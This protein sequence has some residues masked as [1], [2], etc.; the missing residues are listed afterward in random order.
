MDVN[1]RIEQFAKMAEADPENELGHFSLGKAL[2]EA[3][4]Y[5]EAV[6]SL[7]RVIELNREFS[8]AYQVLAFAQMSM[9]EP[10][11]ALVTL[12]TGIPIADT[13]GDRIPRDEMAAM[14]RELGETPPDFAAATAAAE[15]TGG[16]DLRCSRCGRPSKRMERPP[17]KGELGQRVQDNV[18]QTCWRE[19]VSMGT[20]V[21]NE[22]GLQLANPKSQEA[23]DEHM[24]EFLQI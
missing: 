15:P 2:V 12:R 8:K 5:E 9:G 13:R 4:R 6:P 22:L 11:A 20:K 23:Y 3:E 19:W 7:Q 18:C 24:I 16:A 17:F 21:I 14:M 10:S 1:A